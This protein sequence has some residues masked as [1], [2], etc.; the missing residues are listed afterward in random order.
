[1]S[2][3]PILWEETVQGGATWSH[4]LK[5][6]TALRITDMEGGANVGALFYN[7]SARWSATTCRTR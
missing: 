3:T 4:V 7:L 2:E 5:R 1:M 6:G